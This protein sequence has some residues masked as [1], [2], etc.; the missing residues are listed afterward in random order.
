MHQRTHL[1]GYD[2]SDDGKLAAYS[3]SGSNARLT[4]RKRAETMKRVRREPEVARH[5]VDKYNLARMPCHQQREVDI[6]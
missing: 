1:G 2:V 3:L 4:A 6:A 5:N